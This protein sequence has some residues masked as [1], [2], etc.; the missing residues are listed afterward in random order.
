MRSR[1]SDLARRIGEIADSTD[2]SFSHLVGLAR[3]DPKID[4]RGADLSG[5]DFGAVDFTGYDFTDADLSNANLSQVRNFNNARLVRANLDNAQLPTA[6]DISKRIDDVF[7]AKTATIASRRLVHDSLWLFMNSERLRIR[8]Q[9]GKRLGQQM[10]LFPDNDYG[11][12]VSRVCFALP[13]TISMTSFHHWYALQM[14]GAW[15]TLLLRSG[16]PNLSKYVWVKAWVRPAQDSW[17]KPAHV[18][19]EHFDIVV[20]PLTIRSPQQVRLQRLVAGTTTSTASARFV[21]SQYC[22]TFHEELKI[23][24]SKASSTLL[25]IRSQ[26]EEVRAMVEHAFAKRSRP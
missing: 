26:P 5:V 20:A 10:S 11:I 14:R 1:L 18:D 2:T 24:R 17:I 8:A 6:D 9:D 3:L 25:E 23:S 13:K 4:F 7:L 16:R 15:R 21:A 19:E 12:S 22:D